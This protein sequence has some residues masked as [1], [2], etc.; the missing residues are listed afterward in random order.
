MNDHFTCNDCGHEEIVPVTEDT[1][2]FSQEQGKFVC[3]IC[4]SGDVDI[5]H[6]NDGGE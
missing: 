4:G 5:E 3:N 2:T 6:D 1:V